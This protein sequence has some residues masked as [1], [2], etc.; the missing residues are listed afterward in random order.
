MN[1]L[2][3]SRACNMKI[4]LLIVIAL[5]IILSSCSTSRTWVVKRWQNGGIIGYEGEQHDLYSEIKNKTHCKHFKIVR[6]VYKSKRAAIDRYYDQS[7]DING[8]SDNKS[9]HS[10]H[11]RTPSSKDSTPN[12]YNSL[13]WREVT[14]KCLYHPYF[15]YSKNDKRRKPA[16]SYYDTPKGRSNL[17]YC[18][19][20]YGFGCE[21]VD[22]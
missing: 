16:E 18:H 6:H 10:Y 22:Y 15:D 13:F 12:H 5:S 4:R 14:Y 2:I 17:P 8:L 3:I 7:Q 20:Y 21:P 11:Q 19:G 1:G 9:G